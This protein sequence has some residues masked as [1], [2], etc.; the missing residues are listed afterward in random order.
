MGFN[1][2]LKR[3]GVKPP[4]RPLQPTGNGLQSG[5]GRL[6]ASRQRPNGG[7]RQRMEP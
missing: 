2:V 4:K 6:A 5:A 7:V 3:Y 1:I